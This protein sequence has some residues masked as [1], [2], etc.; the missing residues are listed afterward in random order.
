MA[1]T[2]VTG[3]LLGTLAALSAGCQ[4]RPRLAPVEGT[5]TLGGEPLAGVI[6][7][8]H[9]DSGTSGPRSTSEPT[10]QAGRYRLRCTRGGE[11]AVLG[12]HRVCILDARRVPLLLPGGAAEKAASSREIREAMERFKQPPAVCIPARYGRPTQT[13]LRAEVRPG[14]QVINLDLEPQ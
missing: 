3:L 4:D 7:E 13:P 14:T 6:V 2:K 1:P 8:F 9:P 12:S 10:D 5:V 11:G